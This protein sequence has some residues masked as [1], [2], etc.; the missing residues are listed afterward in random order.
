MEKE[1][2]KGKELLPDEMEGVAGGLVLRNDADQNQPEG[3]AGGH[4][5]FRI[6]DGISEPSHV[7]A[8]HELSLEDL[9]RVSGGKIEDIVTDPTQIENL[10]A[11][12]YSIITKDGK[13]LT[14]EE[15]KQ[16]AASYL[17]MAKTIY[18]T[19]TQQDLIDFVDDHY[20]EV[21]GIQ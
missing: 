7:L 6:K 20:N 1:E 9:D 14:K 4:V 12:L 13:T 2:M 3:L 21:M 16:A 15:A 8:K 10:K 18:P 17:F 5:N 19:V 11:L